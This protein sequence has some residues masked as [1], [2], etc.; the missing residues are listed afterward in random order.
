LQP[1]SLLAT[2]RETNR[3]TAHWLWL[4]PEKREKPLHL[5]KTWRVEKKWTFREK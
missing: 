2:I 4:D 3:D 5:S 1:V